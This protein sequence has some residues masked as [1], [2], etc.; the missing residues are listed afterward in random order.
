M[1]PVKI[2]L[3]RGDSLRLQLDYYSSTLRGVKITSAT[4]GLPAVL[5]APSHGLTT[6]DTAAV[7][8]VP[9]IMDDV[10][11]PPSNSNFVN[12]T[13]IDADTVS[14][15]N[16]KYDADTLYKNGGMLVSRIRVNLTGCSVSCQV[17][18]DD[19]TVATMAVS[20]GRNIALSLP[21]DSGVQSGDVADVQVTF[22]DGS[23]QTIAAYEF[24]VDED[25]TR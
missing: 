9:G 17:R 13:V 8:D 7:Y 6:G 1:R 15:D 20:I 23:V 2:S 19:V 12:V 4:A 14:L 22:A 18:R 25:V 3:V 16:V 24:E 21:P 5:H 11:Y 10:V